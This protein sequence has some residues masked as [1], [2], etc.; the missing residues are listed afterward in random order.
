MPWPAR[1]GNHRETEADLHCMRLLILNRRGCTA[2]AIS[3][4]HAPQL[5]HIRTAGHTLSSLVRR[6]H[7]WLACRARSRRLRNSLALRTRRP[8]RPSCLPR[9]AASRAERGAGEACDL[10]SSVPVDDARCFVRMLPQKMACPH[11][12]W[13]GQASC[14]QKGGSQ[15]LVQ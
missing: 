15:L 5:A 11:S 8:W 10:N 2:A 3:A 12:A 14:A 4:Q 1:H 9:A 7:P 13:G 6:Q